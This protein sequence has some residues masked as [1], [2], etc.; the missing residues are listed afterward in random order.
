MSS[1]R[2]ARPL[3]RRRP[4]SNRLGAALRNRPGL[5][6]LAVGVVLAGILFVLPGLGAPTWLAAAS[7]VLGLLAYTLTSAIYYWTPESGDESPQLKSLRRLRVGIA[8]QCQLHADS[9]AL[10]QV[11]TDAL[12][13]LDEEMIPSAE[14]LQQ[15]HALLGRD[16]QRFRSGE[17]LSPDQERLAQLTALY[18][19]QER[20]A[21][22]VGQQVANAYASLL[23]LTQQ[24]DDDARLTA[25]AR[26]WSNELF[27]TQANLAELLD[28]ETAFDRALKERSRHRG[29]T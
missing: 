14:R 20:V 3:V 26:Q 17:M 18:E 11:L 6:L 1:Q 13:R 24:V 7:L 5:S 19:R 21:E 29:S 8:E 9:E 22:N 15:R 10:H 4:T 12:R 2:P 25:D 28:E 27:E 23:M 16:L